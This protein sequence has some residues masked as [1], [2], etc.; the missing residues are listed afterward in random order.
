[1]Y[2]PGGVFIAIL[3]GASIVASLANLGFD[4]Y[5]HIKGCCG[6]YPSACRYRDE[7]D[8]T[9][10]TLTAKSR[11]IDNI[12][13]NGIFSILLNHSLQHSFSFV[14]SCCIFGNTVFWH[15]LTLF[16]NS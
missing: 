8:R 1:V 12:W 2:L 9:K 11:N 15:M 16:S 13:T 3:V 10:K 6:V 14:L 5:L 4:I 7:F